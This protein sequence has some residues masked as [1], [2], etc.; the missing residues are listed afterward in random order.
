MINAAYTYNKVDYQF[1]NVNNGVAFPFDYSIPH[2]F[3]IGSNYYISNRWTLSMDWYFASGKPYTLYSSI[4]KF[5][6]FDRDTETNNILEVISDG[7]N[8][9]RLPDSHK[10][11]M[12]LSTYWNW[13]KARSDLMIGVQ[14]IYNRKNVIYQYELDFEGLQQQLGLALFPMVRWR[15]GW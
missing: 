6:P 9:D 13:G 4:G 8:S 1:D 7:Y 2:T 3:S 5:S 10:L 14:N 11:S 12:S 15:V